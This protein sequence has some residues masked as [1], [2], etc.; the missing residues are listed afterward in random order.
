MSYL[1][2][3]NCWVSVVYKRGNGNRSLY[4]YLNQYVRGCKKGQLLYV[5]LVQGKRMKKW[6]MSLFRRVLSAIVPI[7]MMVVHVKNIDRK[8]TIWN[9]GQILLRVNC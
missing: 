3:V 9:S 7:S 2:L 1:S 6:P 5:Y 8:L 4:V